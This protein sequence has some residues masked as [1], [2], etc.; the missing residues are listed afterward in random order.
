MTASGT[1]GAA[2]VTGVVVS[3]V[4]QAFPIT[5]AISG[6]EASTGALE[7]TDG[8]NTASVA[9]SGS[10]TFPTSLPSGTAYAF[11]V[12]S[13]PA[14]PNQTCVVTSGNATRRGDHRSVTINLAC[15]P[16][17]YTVSVVVSNPDCEIY[18]PAGEELYP[19]GTS[20]TISA[21]PGPVG[22]G[23]GSFGP[24][25]CYMETTPA[26][27]SLANPVPTVPLGDE[28]NEIFGQGQFAG[29]NVTY[30]VTCFPVGEG[31]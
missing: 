16:I 4:T 14:G 5:V 19:D 1:I 13:Q 27:E 18:T 12:E 25:T 9:A 10:V 21:D 15:A 31:G 20:Y 23:N 26:G 8:V 11:S 29:Q 30:D 17:S 6:L 24:C 3:C 2:P 22:P 7:I 28:A